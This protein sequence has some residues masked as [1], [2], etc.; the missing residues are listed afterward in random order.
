MK[1]RQSCAGRPPPVTPSGSRIVVIAHPDPGD[2]IRAPAE[3]PGVAE[4]LAGA[5]LS[6]DRPT[7]PGCPAGSGL[8]CLDQH[9][10]DLGGA[11]G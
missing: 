7:K 8:D 10:G 3:E 9:I 4:V 11:S 5:G 2:K 6:G 1:A